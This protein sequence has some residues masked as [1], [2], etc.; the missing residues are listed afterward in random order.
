MITIQNLEVNFEVEGDD[1]QRFAKLFKDY[2]CKW[3]AEA[4]VQKTRD[5]RSARE[6]SLGDRPV[7]GELA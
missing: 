6:R 4:E 7:E 1:N 5:L 2:M 3:C